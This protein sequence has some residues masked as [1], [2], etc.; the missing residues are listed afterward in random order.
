MPCI[1]AAV[2]VYAVG[3]VCCIPL[4]AGDLQYG[5]SAE[6]ELVV[7]HGAHSTKAAPT[8]MHRMMLF[9]RQHAWTMTCS[10]ER[11]GPLLELS[12]SSD[13]HAAAR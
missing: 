13:C 8:S 12:L 9:L 2:D 5:F 6:L 7:V 1:N 4:L 10:V 11:H 3:A